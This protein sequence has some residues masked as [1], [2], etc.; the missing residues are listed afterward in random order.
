[1]K[2]LVDQVFAHFEQD[3]LTLSK[4]GSLSLI[5]KDSNSILINELHTFGCNTSFVALFEEK[6]VDFLNLLSLSCQL[7]FKRVLEH[8]H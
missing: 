4:L 3:L 7:T 6:V 8:I 5:N 1:M 2:R